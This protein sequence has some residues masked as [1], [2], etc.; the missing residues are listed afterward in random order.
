MSVCFLALLFKPSNFFNSFLV[1]TL[2]GPPD[3]KFSV[4]VSIALSIEVFIFIPYSENFHNSCLGIPNLLIPLSIFSPINLSVCGIPDFSLAKTLDIPVSVGPTTLVDAS[5]TTLDPPFNAGPTKLNAPINAVPSA[6]N[7]NLFLNTA[8]AYSFG[9]LIPSKL[10]S[11]VVTKAFSK[12]FP[13]GSPKIS[14]KV[15]CPVADTVVSAANA[16]NTQ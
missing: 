3:L 13:S 2:K 15:F 7:F 16:G 9:S 6:P 1:C 14:P 10:S 5:P 11:C 4:N 12:K 8:A